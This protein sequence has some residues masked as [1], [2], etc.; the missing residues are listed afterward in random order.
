MAP[1]MGQNKFVQLPRIFQGHKFQHCF[2]P[3][4]R[5]RVFSPVIIIHFPASVNWGQKM[6]PLPAFSCIHSP[7][8]V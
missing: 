7:V 8:R 2:L 3:L 4:A 5:I 1:G 6:G